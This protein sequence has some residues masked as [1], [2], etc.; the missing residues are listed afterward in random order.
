MARWINTVTI[1]MPRNGTTSQ[2]VSPASSGT[3][4]AGAYFTP[5]AN[6]RLVLVGYGPTTLSTPTGWT[7]PTNGSAVNNGGLYVWHRVAAG[8]DSITTT[9]ASN[10]ATV[11]TFYEFASGSTFL[12]SAQAVNVATAGGAGPTLSLSAGTKLVIAAAGQD[13]SVTS[14]TPTFGSWTNAAVENVDTS[15]IAA[16][17]HGYAHGQAYIEDSTATSIA[18]ATTL[19]TSE[20]NT[21]ERLMFAVQVVG[22][23]AAP[24]RFRTIGKRR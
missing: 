21:I 12:A 11:F 6:S 15:T 9:T 14:G 18:V 7:L 19:T 3:V 16:A 17:T 2:T 23:A 1:A 24:I 13:Y 4:V 22:G 10:A 5:T 20:T 8:A